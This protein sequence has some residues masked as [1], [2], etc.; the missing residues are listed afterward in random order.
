MTMPLLVGALLVGLT[1]LIQGFG[2]IT[3][4]RLLFRHLLD[5][6]G[7]VRPNRALTA[8]VVTV[9]GLLLLHSV[10]ILVWA[11]AF[12]LL[13]P[14]QTIDTLEAAI[15]FSAVTFTTLGY[16]DITLSSEQWRLLTGIEALNGVLLLG[17]STA[18]LYAVVHRTWSGY[19]EHH[20]RR[21]DAVRQPGSE[22]RQGSD[23]AHTG[24]G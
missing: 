8:V 19:A 14:V 18:L 3:L 17:W 13:T 5:A 6:N 15:Y 21:A 22:A 23:P 11:V 10:Q 2:S 16:G 7:H 12:R 9:L 1:V 4:M 20:L 24:R